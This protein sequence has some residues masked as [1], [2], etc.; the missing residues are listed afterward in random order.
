LKEID[1]DF[2]IPTVIHAGHFSLTIA[3]TTAADNLVELSSNSPAVQEIV[4][5]A[6]MTWQAGCELVSRF[7]VGNA[8]IM[9]LVN[10][11][12]LL[13]FSS[14]SQRECEHLASQARKDYYKRT[15]RIP[16]LLGNILKHYRLRPDAI[17]KHREDRWLF[18]EAELRS[19]LAKT[20]SLLL[21]DTQKAHSLGLTRH[22]TPNGDPIVHA[23]NEDGADFCLIYC[24]NTNCAGE[25]LQL[26]G[27]LQERGVKRFIN[28]YPMQ[29]RQPVCTGTDLAYRIF[30][31]QEME[32]INIALMGL[33]QKRFHAV[34]DRPFISG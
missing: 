16:L 8:T 20:V 17:L 11:W 15:P 7:P 33:P 9:T 32:V 31:L 19:R 6:S 18:S 10:D 29:C 27:D 34:V 2:S 4:D 24:G 1:G 21:R 26:L 13:K 3:G 5:L 14:E 12:Q 22:F 25:V 28:L 30:G 23:T